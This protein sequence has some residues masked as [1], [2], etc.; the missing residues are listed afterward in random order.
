MKLKDYMVQ[1]G[2]SFRLKD[3]PQRVEDP[4]ESR[5]AAQ[6]EMQKNLEELQE[7]QAKLYAQNRW[8]LLLVIQAMDAAGKDGLIKHVMSGVNPQGCQ[9]ASFKQPSLEERDHDYL[10]RIAKRLPERGNIGIFNR[11]Y[12]EDV[13]VVR[14]HN[15]LNHS[16]LPPSVLGDDIWQRRFS[17]IRHFER[18]LVENGI[19]PI[20]IFLNVSKEEQRRRFLDRIDDPT[21]NWKF[22][23]AD[24]REREYWDDYM[25]AY[26]E[27]I[28]NTATKAAPWHVI[29]ADRKWFARLLTSEILVET[30][31]SL[32]LS[33]PKLPKEELEEL[34]RAKESLLAQ[35]R[36]E[37]ARES[38]K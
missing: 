35:G 16:Q 30:L 17:Q 37:H 33:Y 38:K 18:Y 25:H 11:S 3:H 32:D 10:W 8:S 20:K 9:V 6:A 7:L 21:K 29:P 2:T 27:A 5:E 26:E 15:L 22:S 19:L 31:K 23:C 28:A 34:A 12:Y 1:D 14:V 24:I 4:F 36:T 13:L